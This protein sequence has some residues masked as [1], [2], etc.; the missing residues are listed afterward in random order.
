MFGGTFRSTKICR[1]GHQSSKNDPFGVYSISI[2]EGNNMDLADHPLDAE[3]TERLE[4][5]D[6][7]FCTQ[8]AKKVDAISHEK[9][10]HCKQFIVIRFKRF[11]YDATTE[12]ATK[13]RTPIKYPEELALE[14]F[15]PLLPFCWRQACIISRVASCMKEYLK[16]VATTGVF[17]KHRTICGINVM[18]KQLPGLTRK[19]PVVQ[20][21]IWYY[22][23][24]HSLM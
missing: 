3:Y 19:I 18:T 4:G 24:Y 21:H 12:Q 9:S 11:G 5:E 2:P 8:C 17:Y 14:T 20:M 13:N 7:F 22:M 16:I 1:E 15:P 23:N 10:D 6:Q